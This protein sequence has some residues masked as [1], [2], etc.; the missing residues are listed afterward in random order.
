MKT[1]CALLTCAAALGVGAISASADTNT[2]ASVQSPNAL[3]CVFGGPVYVLGHQV[4]GPF[5]I[6]LPTP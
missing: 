4:I 3:T 2:S 6:C 5:E 1:L